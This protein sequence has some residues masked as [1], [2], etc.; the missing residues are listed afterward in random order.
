MAT[1]SQVQATGP[2][3]S[4]GRQ[5]A[6]PV[7]SGA[8]PPLA[9]VFSAR[10]ETSP[11]LGAALVP[12]AAVALVPAEAAATGSPRDWLGACGKTQLA[13]CFAESLWQSRGVDLLVWVVAASR[14]SVLSGYVAA[15]AAAGSDHVGDAESAAAYFIDWLR[16]TSRPW[17]VVLDDLC[18]AAD[19][20][21]LWPEGSAGRVLI[22]T[23]NRATLSDEHPAL[24]LPVRAFSTRE[25][26]TYLMGRLTADPDQ[27]IGAIDLVGDLGCEPIALA[28]ASAMIASSGLSCRDY[29]DYFAQRR[30]Q[31]AEFGNGKLSAAAVTWTLSI[32]QAE[33]LAPGGGAQ[34]M[35]ALAALFDGHE[36]PSSVFTTSAVCDFL[37]P[38]S[39]GHA[40]GPNGAWRALLTLER[41]GLLTIDSASTPPTVR[42]NR[43][44][45][46]SIRAATTKEVFDQAAK[47]VADALLKVW[48]EDEP[49]GWIAADLRSCAVG[50]QRNAGDSLL[51]RDSIHPVLLQA[52]RSMDSAGLTGPAISYWREIAA[53]ADRAFGPG[54]PDTLT[55]GNHLANALRAA[56]LA[57]EAL[58]WS[59]WALAGRTRVLGRDHPD[60][61][62]SRI[63]LGRAFVAA[64][65]PDDALSVLRDAVAD[66]E[67]VRGGDHLD[68]LASRDEL[69]AARRGAGKPDDAIQLY[70]RTLA[71]RERIQGSR[72]PDTMT[73]RQLLAD[74]YLEQGRTKDAISQLKKVL[75]DRERVLGRSHLDTIVARGSLASAYH[76][77]GKM[78]SALLLYEQARQGYERVLGADHPETL[79]NRGSL[80]YA[81]HAAGRVGDATS[82]L[83]DTVELC[84]QAL[85]PG[86][87]L[88]QALR[89]SLTNIAGD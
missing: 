51:A 46:S 60:T 26:L 79:A 38:D 68:T 12:G 30:A 19:L 59:Q 72:H 25:A 89:E 73:T 49:Q 20:E 88:T 1:D 2:T 6:W 4:L 67:R 45:Q 65:R 54:N 34:H 32:E 85:P 71:D 58:A 24:A 35:L 27:R 18:N 70:R 63:D 21:G 5:A 82:L 36:I 40:A 77:A 29:R 16:Q 56:G 11:G 9:D 87:P 76:T 50:L 44:V 7:R 86:D 17:L 69:A 23:A 33:R 37:P 10:P 41:T 84:E 81:Y 52:G 53:V 3:G 8:V 55:A 57:G 42:V 48:P 31:I 13:A 62:A 66:C 80:A 78:A 43:T 74:V 83:R 39:S 14:A 61:I 64:S 75:S 22:T 28:Q 47:A 15:A